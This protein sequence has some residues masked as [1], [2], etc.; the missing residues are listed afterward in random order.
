MDFIFLDS[1]IVEQLHKMQIDNFGGSH[2]LRDEGMLESALSRPINK[3]E[4]GVG[5]VCELA[6][7]YV[8]GLAKNHPFVDGNKRI[9]IVTA[10]IFLMENGYMIET[11]DGKLY[12][13]VIGIAAGE[14]N[15]DGITRFLKDHVIALT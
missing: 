1:K 10:G 8:F 4:Y 6:A 15:E 13:F 14:I 9:A 7:A 5:D 11:D 2:G 12:E 3:A